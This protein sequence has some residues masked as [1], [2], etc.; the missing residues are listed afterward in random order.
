[1]EPTLE[2][3]CSCYNDPCASVRLQS[4]QQLSAFSLSQAQITE[5]LLPSLNHFLDDSEEVLLQVIEL[6]VSFKDRILDT[7]QKDVLFIPLETLAGI[8]EERVREQAVKGIITLVRFFRMNEQPEV[9]LALV[10]R[11]F[12]HSNEN[13]A[14]SAVDL[15]EACFSEVGESLQ[16]QQAELMHAKY[17]SCKLC[18]R[19]RISSCVLS[20]VSCPSPCSL[21]HPFLPVFLTSEDDFTRVAGVELLACLGENIASFPAL[22]SDCSWKVRYTLAKRFSL[23][24]CPSNE[25]QLHQVFL[26]F[27]QDSEKEVQGAAFDSLASVCERCSSAAFASE[28]LEVVR[29]LVEDR[30]E[31]EPALLRSVIRLAPVVGRPLAATYLLP[32]VERLAATDALLCILQEVGALHAVGGK[33]YIE[34]AYLQ[35]F[36]QMAENKQWKKRGQ[37]IALIPSITHALGIQFYLDNLHKLASKALGDLAHAVRTQAIETIREIA[38]KYQSRELERRIIEEISEKSKSEAFLSRITA[39]VWLEKVVGVMEGERVADEVREVIERLTGDKVANVRICLGK[40]AR[41]IVAECRVERVVQEARKCI[42]ILRKDGDV[43]VRNTVE[44]S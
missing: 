37:A 42:E 14:L 35:A 22:L 8:I 2:S 17:P 6:V 11:L 26:A 16:E 24:L 43:D 13:S 28:L 7:V 31:L 36:Y 4:L 40:L 30:A 1:M 5:C 3:I 9:F 18:V 21:F 41:K 38:E 34:A 20:L 27:L 33:E 15:I 19:H 12:D 39:T 29:G 32:T 23:L 44:D 25:A 10:R